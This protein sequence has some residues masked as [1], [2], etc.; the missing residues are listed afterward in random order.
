M[1]TDSLKGLLAQ[2][3]RLGVEPPRCALI[4]LVGWWI[5]LVVCREMRHV[6]L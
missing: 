2:L 1:Y 5:K 4:I 6:A 3:L